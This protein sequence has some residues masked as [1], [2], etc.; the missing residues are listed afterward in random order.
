MELALQKDI[1]VGFFRA[2]M[3][4]Y[5]G[6]PSSIPLIR[7]EVVDTYEWMTDDEFGDVL[8][9]GNTLPG[10]IA[11][12]MAGYIGYRVA[13]IVGL[14]TAIMAT[15]VPSVLLMIILIGF[16]SSFRDSPSVQGMT[17][18]VTP[19]V[20]VMLGVLAYDFFKQSRK[21][22]GIVWAIVL[23]VVSLVGMQF[24]GLHPAI[25][26]V[27]LMAFGFWLGNRRK[28]HSS[29]DGDKKGAQS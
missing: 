3:L 23:C 16:L 19:V 24:V 22:L 26:I 27:V 20:G 2:G 7:K 18:A 12:K 6:G 25:I 4:G 28:G 9:L 10:P 11:P 15:I 13:G 8:A 1:F 14:F 17:Q 5:G 29:S 21:G